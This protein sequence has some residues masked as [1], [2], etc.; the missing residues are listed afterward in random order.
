MAT[1]F[2][3]FA[4]AHMRECGRMNYGIAGSRLQESSSTIFGRGHVEPNRRRPIAATPGRANHVVTR[5]AQ[6]GHGYRGQRTRSHR[7]HVHRPTCCE[8]SGQLASPS[9]TRQYCF[10]FLLANCSTE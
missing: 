7:W 1:L 5:G 3:R 9:T 6:S 4:E 10:N 8:P 2:I